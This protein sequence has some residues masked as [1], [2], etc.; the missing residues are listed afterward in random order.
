MGISNTIPPSR[1]IQPGVVANTAARPTSPFEGQAIYQTDTDEVLYYN[2]TSW[3]RPWNMPWGQVGYVR[4]TTGDTTVTTSMTDIV[5][6]TTTFTAVSGRLYAAQF[7]CQTRKLGA[8]GYIDF[9][10][11]DGSNNIY[12][13]FFT[14][15]AQNEY[16]A[17]SWSMLLPSLSG[18]ITVKMR[19]A[20]EA[21]TAY[22]WGSA[23]NASSF[24][25]QD[26][27]PA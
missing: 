26:I 8:A 2:G 22:I 14:N 20:A 5:G 11:S 3:S 17:F 21:G 15:Y 25:I 13:D 1:L 16:A 12:S 9:N 10:L 6:V 23:G 4:R 24:I 7:S 19:A 18:S 27:G